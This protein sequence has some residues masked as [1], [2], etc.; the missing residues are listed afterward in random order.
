[1][2]LMGHMMHPAVTQCW[3]S[4]VVTV[5]PGPL[6][7]HRNLHPYI[8]GIGRGSYQ[9]KKRWLATNAKVL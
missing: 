6:D 8:G 9:V 7:P 1:M 4:Q 5:I 2:S 3:V